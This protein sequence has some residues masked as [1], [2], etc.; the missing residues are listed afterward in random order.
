MRHS[1][2]LHLVAWIISSI[3]TWKKTIY[4]RRFKS[5]W[6]YGE[7]T[8][9]GKTSVAFSNFAAVDNNKLVL[10]RILFKNVELT[11]FLF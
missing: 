7:L 10:T 2:K 11:S 4:S 1:W 8:P 9:L 6:K 3:E 5:E